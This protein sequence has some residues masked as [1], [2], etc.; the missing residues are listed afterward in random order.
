MNPDDR[1]FARTATVRVVTRAAGWDLHTVNPTELAQGSVF[2]YVFDHETSKVLACCVSKEKFHEVRQGLVEVPMDDAVI[3]TYRAIRAVVG[4]ATATALA[5]TELA[6]ALTAY[7]SKTGAYARSDNANTA[8]HFVV[9][10]Y[11]KTNRLRPFALSGGDRYML[12]SSDVLSAIDS[13]IQL[14]RERHPDWVS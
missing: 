2:F 5:E 9:I 12:E 14:D 4:V 13:V 6:I 8:P 11:G 7:I 3:A 10:H 1:Q